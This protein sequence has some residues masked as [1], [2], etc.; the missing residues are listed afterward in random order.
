MWTTRGRLSRL[1]PARRC[2]FA[3]TLRSQV[4]QAWPPWVVRGAACQV[5][6][7]SSVNQTVRLSRRRK[8]ASYAAHSVVLRFRFGTWWGRAALA[9]KGMTRTQIRTGLPPI[10]TTPD[11]QP[12]IRATTPPCSPTI[13]RTFR[14]SGG[15][16]VSG[17]RSV[18]PNRPGLSGLLGSPSK[19]KPIRRETFAPSSEY[20]AAADPTEQVA[21]GFFKTAVQG[22]LRAVAGQVRR[23]LC[24]Y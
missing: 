8:L 16:P 12:L 13:H 23:N 7:A 5:A 15:A 18:L 10:E 22:E 6:I 4:H 20:R 3:W 24:G 11:H 1:G 2:R 19:T 9:L 17:C 14:G 21:M